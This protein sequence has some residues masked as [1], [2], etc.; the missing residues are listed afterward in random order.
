MKTILTIFLQVDLLFQQAIAKAQDQKTLNESCSI[1]LSMYNFF[2]SAPINEHHGDNLQ[3]IKLHQFSEA[4][5]TVIAPFLP[6]EFSEFFKQLTLQD[7]P[8]CILDLH[9]YSA[10]FPFEIVKS[11]FSKILQ[12][13]HSN[14]KISQDKSSGVIE[15]NTI[16]IACNDF[17]M[18]AP[19]ENGE[20]TGKVFTPFETFENFEEYISS[21]L[22]LHVA[23]TVNR[24]LTVRF[25]F[26]ACNKLSQ[27]ESANHH[28]FNQTLQQV[29]SCGNQ[30]SVGMIVFTTSESNND[31]TLIS[32]IKDCDSCIQVIN[33]MNKL[34]I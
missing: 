22:K 31:K 20:T 7:S 3:G 30:S 2:V 26:D 12:D 19:D 11:T 32:V 17:E 6:I 33:S 13:I 21:I 34:R 16:H 25:L 18:F 4:A 23:K 24:R 5:V 15:R 29:S 8:S 1:A 9:L 28:L 27:G 10:F 14:W